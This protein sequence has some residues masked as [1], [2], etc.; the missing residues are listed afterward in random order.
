MKLSALLCAFAACLFAQ[1]YTGPRCEPIPEIQKA[2]QEI[3][4]DSSHPMPARLDW[5]AS[6]WQRW[7]AKYPRETV[8]HR[9]YFLL[10]RDNIPEKVETVRRHYLQQAK[11]HPD[12]VLAV[13]MAGLVMEGVNTPEAIQTLERAVK[14]DPGFGWNYLTLAYLYG[15]GKFQDKPKAAANMAAYFKACPQNVESFSISM[16]N[17][18]GTPETIAAAAKS[19]RQRLETETDPKGLQSF[20]DLWGL[21]FKMTPVAEHPKLRARVAADL[22]R[23]EALNPKP[24]ADWLLFL[25]GGLKQSGGQKEVPALE[26]RIIRELPGSW[27]AMQIVNRRWDEAHPRPGVTDSAE[28]WD[29]YTREH[30]AAVEG[31]MKQ[32]PEQEAPLLSMQFADAA[33]PQTDPRRLREIGDRFVSVADE[34]YGPSAVTPIQVARAYLRY[35]VDPARALELLESARPLLFKEQKAQLWRDDLTD[36]NRKSIAEW[37]D[38]EQIGWAGAMATAFRRTGMGDKAAPLW[39]LVHPI[40][41]AKP[42][43]QA[44]RFA[45]L[46]EIAAAQGKYTDAL[47]LY[48]AALDTR[49]KPPAPLRGRVDDEVLD[50]AHEIWK[51]SGGSEELWALWSKPPVRTGREITD[52]RW[53]Q[54]RKP[55]PAFELSD[56]AG[57]KWTLKTLEGKTLFINL[58]ATWCGPCMAELPHFQKLYERTKDRSDVVVLSL[59]VDDEVGLVEPFMK[60]KGYSF[61]VLLAAS[62]A[63]SVA[64]PLGIPQ[65]WIVDRAGIWQWQ[66]LGYDGDPNW[67]QSMLEKLR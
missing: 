30:T 17:Q 40:Q 38:S 63:N 5:Q 62:Y 3:W 16:L 65:N 29:R 53:E 24:D 56:L 51:L 60:E 22:K 23:L 33:I 41:P 57:K 37:Q 58:W 10:F 34:K 67:E 48:K 2:V 49:T 31:W 13:Y 15:R 12:D 50:G 20:S 6:E 39:D 18:Y 55:L 25:I 27:S 42:D 43:L 45:A 64:G 66:Q 11:E 35:G 14:L 8:L 7:L 19:I 21:E 28:T 26:D 9:R 61:P 4:N 46:A 32:F 36:D 44:R 54:P 52:S 59:N 47:T 1:S